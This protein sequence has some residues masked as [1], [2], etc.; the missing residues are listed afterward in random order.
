[1]ANS[2]ARDEPS[3]KIIVGVDTHKHEHVAVAINDLGARLAT[4]R[5]SANR[6]GYADLVIWARTLGA[7]EAFGIEGTGSYGVGLARFVRR[8]GL[9]VVEVNHG[10]RRKRRNNGKN[11]TLDAESAA[12]SVLAGVA[13]AIPKVADGTAEMV[14][15]IKIAR[16]TAIKA[17]SVAITTLKTLIVNAP[18]ALREALEPLTDQ[19][20]I[21]RCVALRPGD[22]ID[23]TASA[24]HALRALA[25]RWRTLSAEVAAHD[26]VLDTLTRTATPTLREAVRDWRRLGSRNDDRCRRQP[27][28]DPIRSRVRKAV[29]RVPDSRLERGHE[30]AS[31]FPRRPPPSQ[32]SALPDRDRPHALAPADHRLRPPTHRRG[33]VEERHHP[34]SEALR[35]PGGL[36]RADRRPPSRCGL[37]R[38]CLTWSRSRCPGSRTGRLLL[39]LPSVPPAGSLNSQ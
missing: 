37:R 32:R 21:E 24:K 1:M 28:P 10:D 30:P 39:R 3:V 17:R 7:V 16:D 8:Q 31:A 36:P 15:Q 18:G 22:I 5:A 23:P 12:R 4:C 20:L 26:E 38:G 19:K 11:D 35:R 33:P 27:H 2:I 13:T 25:A 6:A 14:R 9:R 29:R 34:L